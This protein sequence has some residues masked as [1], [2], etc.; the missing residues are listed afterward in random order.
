MSDEQ[1]AAASE[2]RSGEVL[3]AR[4]P[5]QLSEDEVRAAG[6]GRSEEVL[7]PKLARGG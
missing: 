1:V 5:V 4:Q 6:E 7:A 3:G 2:G